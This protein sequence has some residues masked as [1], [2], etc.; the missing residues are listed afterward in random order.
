M[1]SLPILVAGDSRPKQAQMTTLDLIE[2]FN[3]TNVIVSGVGYSI[4]IILGIRLFSVIIIWL[5]DMSYFRWW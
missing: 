1:Q 2:V 3:A 4:A 5:I